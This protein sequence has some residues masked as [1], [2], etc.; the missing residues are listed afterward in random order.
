MTRGKKRQDTVLLEC[1]TKLYFAKL[2]LIIIQVPAPMSE[3]WVI[4]LIFVLILLVVVA[5]GAKHAHKKRS[6]SLETPLSLNQISNSSN[7]G[8]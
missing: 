4:V 2:K 5:G 7:S 8:Q 6:A 1:L 3:G